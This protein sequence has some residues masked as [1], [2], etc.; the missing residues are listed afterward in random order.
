LDDGQMLA[1]N[2]EVT[3]LLLI[4]LHHERVGWHTIVDVLT[5]RPGR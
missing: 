5:D 1:A 2:V 4:H 3:R